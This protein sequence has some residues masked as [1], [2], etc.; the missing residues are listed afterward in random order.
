MSKRE[1]LRPLVTE[2]LQSANRGWTVEEVH[3]TVTDAD[4][5]DA[6]TRLTREVLEELVEDDEV[7]KKRA[8][9]EGPGRP[10]FQYI[11]AS[12][13]AEEDNIL[14]LLR[15]SGSPPPAET[16]FSDLNAKA[17]SIRTTGDE[18]EEIERDEAESAGVQDD[19]FTEI[20]ERHLDESTYIEQIKS[21]APALAGEDPVDL[22][23]EM[24]EWCMQW[25]DEVGRET[26]EEY[27]VGNL[28]RYWRLRRRLEGLL[29]IAD[30]YFVRLFRLDLLTR[31]NGAFDGT[32]GFHRLPGSE[33][34][35][36]TSDSV[37]EHE[38]P[39]L[40]LVVGDEQD[41]ETVAR[42]REAIRDHLDSRI[43]GDTVLGTLEIESVED[44]AGTDGSVADVRLP[45]RRD[46]LAR[47][48]TLQLFSGA[49]ALDR[50]DR[51]YTDYD[52]TPERFRDY[53]ERGAFKKGLMMSPRVFLELSR[54]ELNKARQ[55]AMDL[56]QSNENE[57]AARNLADWEPVGES[58]G[59]DPESGP[60]VIF[61]DGRVF[62]LVHQ[63]PDY[64]NIRIYGELVRNEVKRFVETVQMF[65]EHYTS[66]D[67]DLVGVVKMSMVSFLAPMVFW[68]LD[69]KEAD[70]VP[71]VP[72][73]A[74]DDWEVE[75]VVPRDV[76]SPRLIDAVVANLLFLGLVEERNE[77]DVPIDEDHAFTTFRVPR[78]FWEAS[79]EAKDI[80]PIHPVT[81]E[82]IDV[83]SQEAW[84][85]Y[86][87]LEAVGAEL[88]RGDSVGVNSQVVHEYQTSGGADLADAEE[89]LGVLDEVFNDEPWRWFAAACAQASV[90]MTYGAPQ[91]VYINVA[92]LE[93][94][95]EPLFMLPRLETAISRR[96]PADGE[97]ALRQG[98]S[99]FAENPDLDYQ[100]PFEEYGGASR[101]DEEGLPI[102]VPD[103]VTDSD[104][105][106]RMVQRMMGPRAEQKLG[107]I[108][109]A[110]ERE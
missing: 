96:G 10:P 81:E 29:G 19:A 14:D 12:V 110:L 39:V 51:H 36:H 40:P 66:V 74:D 1:T 34:Y 48:T 21:V 42:Q 103:V 9:G 70:D 25:I 109:D 2:V 46:A 80:P 11:H 27:D 16:I 104:E 99:W 106:A 15:E 86:I 37:Q 94:L 4:G 83:D 18:Q 23:V 30:W 35:Y 93:G 85:E 8:D 91:S 44:A 6:S 53:R 58:S 32:R 41:E 13:V 92:E 107:E 43:Y 60:D 7:E 63:Y 22:A 38:F 75:K 68:Y 28:D 47:E 95:D 62:P 101:D 72:S 24:A 105:A 26:F 65:D 3:D 79:V 90:V 20:A 5:V 77:H 49:A 73:Q 88:R 98:L 54:G 108:I 17:D 89:R 78:H 59:P 64:N 84:L 55:A 31:R 82:W 87:G 102:L 57:R 61:A 100:H 50:G 67:T 56:R 97:S 69:V 52:Y 76:V 45:N 33:D 71:T